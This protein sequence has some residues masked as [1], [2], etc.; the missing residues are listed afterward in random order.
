[1]LSAYI[2]VSFRV[3]VY[4]QILYQLM[5]PSMSTFNSPSSRVVKDS[6]PSRRRILRCLNFGIGES[7]PNLLLNM[8]NLYLD[9]FEAR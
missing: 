9:K 3:S 7:L 6:A 4:S 5:Q 1:M 8:V 2:S